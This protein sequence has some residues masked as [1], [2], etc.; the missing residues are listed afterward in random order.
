MTGTDDDLPISASG[1]PRP[2]VAGTST[3]AVPASPRPALLGALLEVDRGSPFISL[4]NAEELPKRLTGNDLDVALRKGVSLKEASAYAMARARRLGWYPVIV[5]SRGHMVGISFVHRFTPGTVLHLDIFRDIARFGVPLIDGNALESEIR[6][7]R[8]LAVLSPRAEALATL[9]HRV[10]HGGTLNKTKYERQ[11]LEA[12]GNSEIQ[13]WLVDELSRIF[14]S[15][16]SAEVAH[17]IEAGE[18]GSGGPDREREATRA[19]LTQAVRRAPIRTA[20]AL[21]RYLVSQVSSFAQPSGLVGRSGELVPGLHGAILTDDFAA[22]LS[23]TAMRV[24]NVGDPPSAVTIVGPDR[25][26]E[27]ILSRWNSWTWLRH[28][29]PSAFLWLHAKRG[30]VALV[31]DLP[32]G[33]R[34]LRRVGKPS[35]VMSPRRQHRGM[36]LALL[37]PD[38]VGKTTVARM[39]LDGDP[40]NRRYVHYQPHPFR[41]LR[42]GPK[43]DSPPQAWGPE[44]ASVVQTVLG[45][46][47]LARSWCRFW[48]GFLLQV[49]PVLA[50]GGVVVADRWVYRYLTQPRALWYFGPRRLA[51][52]AVRLAPRADLA[53]V[54]HATPEIIRARKAEKSASEIRQEYAAWEG[55]AFPEVVWVDAS[56]EAHAVVRQIEGAISGSRAPKKKSI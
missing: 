36:L 5:N 27:M 8:G 41:P 26:R 31:H 12:L 30:G 49:R 20:L 46:A 28:V 48:A 18:M 33:I 4:R 38:G 32:L 51:Q 11:L 14:G 1:E 23:T 22:A 21:A 40:A 56:Q 13:G 19:V 6:I 55:L 54:L 7:E 52:W 29:W 37:G 25:Y 17:A 45:W 2:R 16:F 34:V 9:V 24:D 39:L 44:N 35:W 3:P 53:V 42:A 43:D 15:T 50:T 47:R 10:L